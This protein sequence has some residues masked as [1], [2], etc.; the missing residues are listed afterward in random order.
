M[1][2]C[3]HEAA[4]EGVAVYERNCG[5]GVALETSALNVYNQLIHQFDGPRANIRQEPLP[6]CE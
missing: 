3:E 4:G 2:H 5:H 1:V 6:E